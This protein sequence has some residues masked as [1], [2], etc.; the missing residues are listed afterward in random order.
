MA[1]LLKLNKVTFLSIEKFYINIYPDIRPDTWQK[2]LPD[3]RPNQYPVQPYK[4][5]HK[6]GHYFLD[7]QYTRMYS[8]EV[9]FFSV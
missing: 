3:I 1:D 5:L 4:L 8:F 7:I 9:Y 6:V 2:Y